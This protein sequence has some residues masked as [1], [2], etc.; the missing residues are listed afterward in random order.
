MKLRFVKFLTSRENEI[1]K[2]EEG[3]YHH[4]LRY[5]HLGRGQ[6]HLSCSRPPPFIISVLFSPPVPPACFLRRPA[7]PPPRVGRA[8]FSSYP[9][10][11][12]L[13]SPFLLHKLLKEQS[14]AAVVP[15]Q[16][17]QLSY[18]TIACGAQL[19]RRSAPS[20]WPACSPPFFAFSCL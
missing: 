14:V 17:V 11:S 6:S 3:G 13:A 19:A 16:P 8:I 7:S 20:R 1:E 2:E 15:S 9:S 5:P 18:P 10:P 12:C 4:V